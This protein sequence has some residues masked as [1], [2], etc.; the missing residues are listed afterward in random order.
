LADASNYSW[1]TT[2]ESGQFNTSQEG[3]TE[4]GGF[5]TLNIQL[6]DNTVQAAMKGSKAAVKTEDG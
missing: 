6:G 1:K 2:T 3:K 5:T 4:K